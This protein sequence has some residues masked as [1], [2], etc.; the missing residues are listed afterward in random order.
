MYTLDY[1]M[2]AIAPIYYVNGTWK[3]S[4]I[5][6]LAYVIVF[7]KYIQFF[8]QLIER[9]GERGGQEM[10]QLKLTILKIPLMWLN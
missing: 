10:G 6:L 4:N 9:D 3:T 7:F 1:L 5:C 8:G 2:T